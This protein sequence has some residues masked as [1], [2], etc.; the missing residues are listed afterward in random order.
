MALG[1]HQT[2]SCDSKHER[3]NAFS[4]R[5]GLRGISNV[6][7]QFKN[8]ERRNAPGRQNRRGSKGDVKRS[9]ALQEFRKKER[10]RKTRI[11]GSWGCILQFK[12]CKK[13]RVLKADVAQ[14]RIANV[15]LRF[16]SS[17]KER[18]IL[19]TD[20]AQGRVSHVCSFLREGFQHSCIARPG[21]QNTH[22]VNASYFEVQHHTAHT[23]RYS[24]STTAPKSQTFKLI[25]PSKMSLPGSTR[26][27]PRSFNRINSP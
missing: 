24:S 5:A 2:W 13:E 15:V 20:G 22:H 26:C 1:V 14:G 25:L 10:F 27:F 19:K 7:L 18:P 6:V 17:K 11:R 3:R 12:T 8:F 9:P 21:N 4:R 16:D 23:L